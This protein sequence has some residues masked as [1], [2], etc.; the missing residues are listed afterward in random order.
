MQGSITPNARA[1]LQR[2][3]PIL[4]DLSEQ[5]DVIAQVLVG[6]GTRGPVKSRS[7]I[8]PVKGAR[9]TG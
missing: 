5:Q 4:K 6:S 2:I 7:G 8:D 3:W 9:I 1:G